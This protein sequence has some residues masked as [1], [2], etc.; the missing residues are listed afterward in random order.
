M[1]VL[2]AFIGFNLRVCTVAFVGHVQGAIKK[3]KSNNYCI[4]ICCIRHKHNKHI[5]FR[6]F[7]PKIKKQ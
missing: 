6:L 3:K 4:L 2:Y 5:L 7:V 1:I